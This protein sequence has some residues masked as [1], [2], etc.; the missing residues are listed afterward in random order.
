MDLLERLG[1]GRAL[2]LQVAP[3]ERHTGTAIEGRV[4]LADGATAAVLRLVPEG[5]P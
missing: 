2:K 5:W 3:G 1:D 4:L